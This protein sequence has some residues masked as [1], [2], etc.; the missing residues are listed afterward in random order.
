MVYIGRFPTNCF[1]MRSSDWS[2]NHMIQFVES[3]NEE[4]FWKPCIAMCV[5]SPALVVI[6]MLKLDSIY[7]YPNMAILCI[8]CMAYTLMGGMKA[9]I[10]TDVIQGIVMVLTILFISGK[11]AIDLGFSYVFEKCEESQAGFDSRLV[12][13]F[14]KCSKTFHSYW[15]EIK[16]LKCNTVLPTW[17][18]ASD[19]FDIRY[20]TP[21]VFFVFR[22]F[23]DTIMMLPLQQSMVQVFKIWKSLHQWTKFTF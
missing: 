2:S 9:V 16:S 22:Q 3:F 19:H 17:L 4:S 20:R 14:K 13:K 8:L 15:L 5:W 10:W 21:P 18:N 23:I 6:T 1:L 7:L 11:L 12:K